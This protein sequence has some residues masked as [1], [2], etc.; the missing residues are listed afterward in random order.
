MPEGASAS[1]T[2]SQVLA[3]QQRGDVLEA[4][5]LAKSR[6]ERGPDDRERDLLRYQAV[7][8]LARSGATQAAEAHYR[9]WRLETA[10]SE[11]HA[12]LAGRLA[13]DRA[14]AASGAR[15]ARLSLRAAEAYLRVFERW[16][17]YFPA[18]NAAT[19][20][21]LAGDAPRAESLAAEV[22][23]LTQAASPRD[24]EEAYFLAA[25]RAEAE[26]L[27]GR[28]REARGAVEESARLAGGNFIAASRTRKQ[29]LLI[30]EVK[31]VDAAILE[32]LRPPTVA[33]FCGLMISPPGEPGRFAAAC[34]PPVARAVARELAQHGVGIGYGALA[35]GAD[36]LF[37]EALLSRGAELHVVLPF[38][39]A[40]FVETSVR[41]GGAGWVERFERC[42][43]QA[44]GVS[45]ATEDG[46][47]GDDSLFEFGNRVA[48]GLAVL[49]ARV[50]D[51]PLRQL[52][53]WDGRGDR[54]VGGTASA[55]GHWEGLGLESI[56]IPSGAVE[57]ESLPVRSPAAAPGRARRELRSLIFSDMRG[58]TKLSEAH[59][60]AFVDTVMKGFGNILDA[61]GEDVLHRNTWGDALYLVL[62]DVRTA[63]E[64]ALALQEFVQETD[65]TALGLPSG[66]SMRLGVHFAPIFEVHDPVL[67]RRS[68]YGSQVSRT[69]RIEPIT[70]PGEIYVTEPFAA[71]LAF[72]GGEAFRCDYVGRVPL[73]KSYGSFRMYRLSRNS[74][75]HAD[76]RAERPV[77]S[78][79]AATRHSSW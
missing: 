40:E 78:P 24:A 75:P 7:L 50:L 66:F 53:V 74:S 17:G 60:P 52:A 69:A 68:Y 51:A 10:Q 1:P 16:R 28:E 20:Y 34:E 73:A 64:C 19:L 46:H 12:A 18:I 41:R 77:K 29:L 35:C 79:R 11:D 27:R 26:L 15:R 57:G 13:K 59:V 5:D 45:L 56:R 9:E 31:R 67:K 38:D 39:R 62:R 61:H 48:M 3:A 22:L 58:F 70:P 65:F 44:R 32:P 54:G 2:L 63:A 71:S 36:I 8:A 4:F 14:L 43:S 6:L 25:T 42:C 76:G 33:H 55:I 21:L 37:A 30:C 72:E 47:L 49:R 23:Q